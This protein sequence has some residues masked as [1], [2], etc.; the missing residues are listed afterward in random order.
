MDLQGK[1]CGKLSGSNDS[2]LVDKMGI[3]LHVDTQERSNGYGTTL[4]MALE[5][6]A[7]YLSVTTV[8]LHVEL[9]SWY[10]E[11][12]IRKGYNTSG[13]SYIQDKLIVMTK[14]ISPL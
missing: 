10:P 9:N 8:W 13:I 6:I 1:S 7:A 11:W 14:S 3:E 2:L 4:L 5:Q 12:L